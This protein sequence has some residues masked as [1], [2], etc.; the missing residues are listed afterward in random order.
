MDEKERLIIKKHELEQLIRDKQEY[1]LDS[2]RLGGQL[3]SYA[4]RPAELASHLQI[5][6]I[7]LEKINSALA[8]YNQGRIDQNEYYP[9][10][11]H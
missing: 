6:N 9:P 7:E 1:Y 2:G 8:Q 5:L 3:S 11:L 4:A 10:E